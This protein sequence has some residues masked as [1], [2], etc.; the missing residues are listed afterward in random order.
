MPGAQERWFWPLLASH[1]AGRGDHWPNQILKILYFWIKP[2]ELIVVLDM[3]WGERGGDD[4]TAGGGG[5]AKPEE[6]G[7]PILARQV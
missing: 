7:G 1:C 3:N 5:A 4:H 2:L 6:K